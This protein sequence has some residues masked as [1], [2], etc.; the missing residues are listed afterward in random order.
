M[1][2]GNGVDVGQ[3]EDIPFVK[4]KATNFAI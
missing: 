4:N 2:T 1:L 3:Q